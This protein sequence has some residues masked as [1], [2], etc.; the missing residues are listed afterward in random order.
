MLHLRHSQDTNVCV[1]VKQLEVQPGF[2]EEK[3]GWGQ[4]LKTHLHGECSLGHKCG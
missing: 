4:R 2:Q 3:H 1:L